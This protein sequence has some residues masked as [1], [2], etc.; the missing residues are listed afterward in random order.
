MSTE[1]L[2]PRPSAAYAVTILEIELGKLRGQ[3]YDY[4]D[5]P[6][7]LALVKR[8]LAEINEALRILGEVA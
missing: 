3:A 2:T 5:H 1:N 4:R 7:S 8:N 6:A